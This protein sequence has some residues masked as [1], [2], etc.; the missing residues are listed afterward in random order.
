MPINQVN[1][2]AAS[3]DRVVPPTKWQFITFLGNNIW[4]D[5]GNGT[6]TLNTYKTINA[7]Q[8]HTDLGVIPDGA[9]VK[10]CANVNAHS[11]APTFELEYASLVTG[12]PM[13]IYVSEYAGGVYVQCGSATQDLIS[14]EVKSQ[15]PLGHD[16]YICVT[17]YLAT[18][19]FDIQVDDIALTGLYFQ[20][21]NG[22]PNDP[23]FVLLTSNF[24]P[25]YA[26][27]SYPAVYFP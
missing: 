19:T 17:F 22:V 16:Y 8:L 2:G 5:D 18:H 11:N 12:A 4:I 13:S 26:I 23:E 9:K 27:F 6:Q 7:G 3:H 1:L 21:T 24:A 14:I 15:E 10:I 25:N 20:K